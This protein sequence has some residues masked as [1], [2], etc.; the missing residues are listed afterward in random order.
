MIGVGHRC[1]PS[2]Q[3]PYS[4]TREDEDDDEAE[5]EEE[6]EYSPTMY[7]NPKFAYLT[8]SHQLGVA[9]LPVEQLFIESILNF[10]SFE[11]V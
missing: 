8:E 2:F 11:D 10:A 6:E 7:R 9:T 5:D 4:W 3:V 1:S